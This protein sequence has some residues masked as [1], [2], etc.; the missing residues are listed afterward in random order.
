[1]VIRQLETME[2]LEFE[3]TLKYVLLP[4][5]E[6]AKRE[7]ASRQQRSGFK[8][9]SARDEGHGRD[10]YMRILRW[11]HGKGVRRVFNLYV[12]DLEEPSHS[13]ETI[14]KALEDIQV[15]KVWDWRRFDL[16]SEVIAQAAPKVSQVNLYWG[17][18]NT[19]LRSW[20]E[21]AG[22]SQ[23]QKLEQVTLHRK[24]VRSFY[25]R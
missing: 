2:F 17:G 19:V 10:D 6:V 23:L 22:L 12:D 13:D 3:D 14:E 18:N 4:R 7:H 5:V 11:L 1:M 9:K 21:P 25:I 24:R 15:L 8:L 20:S 16:S